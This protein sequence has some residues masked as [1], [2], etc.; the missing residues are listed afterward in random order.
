MKQ[1]SKLISGVVL[2]SFVL[3]ACQPAATPPPAATDTPATGP[4]LK[5]CEVTDVGGAD[6]KSYNETAFKGIKQAE[7]QFG[8][9]GLMLESQQQT[10]YAKNINEFLASDCELIVT[11]GFLLG[12]STL[13]AAKANPEQ[14]FMILDYVYT[15]DVPNV[16]QQLYSI[17]QAAFMAGYVAAAATQTGKVGTF[18]GINIPPVVDFMDGFALGVRY[19]N[20]KHNTSVEVLGW[21]PDERDGGLFTGNFESTDDG[22]RFGENLLDEGADI[23]LPVAG[24]VGLGTA[25]AVQEH[26]NAWIIGVDSDWTLSAEEYKDVVLTSVLKKLD[27]TVVQAVEATDKGEFKGGTH[28]AT[29]EN[30]GVGIAPVTNFTVSPELQAELDQLMADIIAG[31]VKTKP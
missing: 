3:A 8:W 5:V 29:L 30:D 26:G 17:D 20:E 1:L 11:V 13:A 28:V 21:N 31:T 2:S 25:A 24:P 7:T 22:R 4:K 9:E 10:D 12:D 15:E 18:G 14:K 16:W 23:I 19:Y 27:V 6:D